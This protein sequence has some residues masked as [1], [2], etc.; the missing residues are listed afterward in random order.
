MLCYNIYPDTYF[1]DFWGQRIAIR[2]GGGIISTDMHTGH[3][4][5][6]GVYL[7]TAIG[8]LF[9]L[10]SYASDEAYVVQ[11][12]RPMSVGSRYEIQTR[13]HMDETLQNFSNS[14]GDMRTRIQWEVRAYASVKEVDS[15]GRP[16]VV[17][18]KILESNTSI[19][20]Q[21]SR[22]LRPGD[23]IQAFGAAAGTQFIKS[24]RQPDVNELR[25][26][27][28]VFSVHNPEGP[29]DSD[30]FDT[31]SPKRIGDSWTMDAQAFVQAMRPVGYSLDP[32][33]TTGY[34]SL[35][36]IREVDGVPCYFLQGEVRTD[37]ASARLRNGLRSGNVQLDLLFTVDYPVDATLQTL[38]EQLDLT[39][40]GTLTAQGISADVTYR[41]RGDYRY[42]HKN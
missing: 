6:C 14:I 9:A 41:V 20:G 2:A 42:I 5:G 34:V 33:M 22:V 19:D 7:A 21:P 40:K 3:I 24:G 12:D 13:G 29:S 16:S 32:G 37:E 36:D 31:E 26:M 38:A 18:F 10:A 23:S 25:L 39:I 30:F 15:K 11:F 1:N 35:R 27:R 4:R 28:Y 17:R 8:I